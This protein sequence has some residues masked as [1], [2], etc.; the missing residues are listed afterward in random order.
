MGGPNTENGRH[1]R[2]RTTVRPKTAP[3]RA[4]DVPVSVDRM[5]TER[6]RISSFGKYL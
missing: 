6:T 1:S 3:T 4:P 2:F 5:L